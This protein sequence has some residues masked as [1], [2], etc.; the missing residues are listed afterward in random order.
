LLD[1]ERPLL[2]Q[3]GEPVPIAGK[4][5]DTLAVLVQNRGRLVD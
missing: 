1:T 4:T 3:D 5:F 2:L